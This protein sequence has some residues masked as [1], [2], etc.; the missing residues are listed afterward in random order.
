MLSEAK[1]ERSEC[2]Q[3]R[4][5]L[6][7]Q[8]SKAKGRE[9]RLK[10][11]LYDQ[12]RKVEARCTEAECKDVD[13]VATA[14]MRSTPHTSARCDS[15]DEK[16]AAYQCKVMYRGTWANLNPNLNPTRDCLQP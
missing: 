8:L 9:T 16:H 15:S 11:K 10:A 5:A 6:E 14:L 7:R 1:D 4:H 2:K 12:N 3:A 13:E